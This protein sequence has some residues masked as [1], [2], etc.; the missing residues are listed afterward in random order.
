[1][2]TALSVDPDDPETMR[3]AGARPDALISVEPTADLKSDLFPDA[4][5]NHFETHP[6]DQ[7]S[8]PL[9]P[10]LAVAQAGLERLKPITG[11]RAVI[12]K[13]ERIGSDVRGPETMEAK[14]R[15]HRDLAGGGVVP[16]AVYLK[17]IQPR[18]VAGRE[19]IWEE[20]ANSGNLVAHETGFANLVTLRLAHRPT[21]H[22]GAAHPITEIGFDVLIQ[23]MIE[24][25]TRDRAVGPCRVEVDRWAVLNGRPCTSITIIH[26]DRHEAFEFHR[27]TIVI[28]DELNLPV[29]YAA[30]DWPAE[31]NAEPQLL[32]EYTYLNIELDP[33]LTAADFD[34][35]NEAYA[36]P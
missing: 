1:M 3:M 4:I 32:E 10:A 29:K 21:R 12:V 6:I 18:G 24:K 17:F 20:G 31:P 14:I 27:A 33:E 11:Y 16:F 34:P 19:V 9:D 8:H 15:R 7:A 22:D 25:G 36:Y 30:Y 2:P 26:D 5:T 35:E 23:R 13:R 28:D